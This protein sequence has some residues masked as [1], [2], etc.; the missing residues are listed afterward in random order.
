L[1]CVKEAPVVREYSSRFLRRERE[2]LARRPRR[3]TCAE[4]AV[5]CAQSLAVRHNAKLAGDLFPAGKV[6]ADWSLAVTITLLAGGVLYSLWKTRRIAQNAK[7]SS[8]DSA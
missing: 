3:D 7:G 6:P 5:R 2:E 1:F 4:A 8:T